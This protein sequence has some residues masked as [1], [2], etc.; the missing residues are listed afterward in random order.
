MA[1]QCCS[2]KYPIAFCETS[3]CESSKKL[4]KPPGV[5]CANLPMGR[6]RST[7]EL[8]RPIARP[9]SQPNAPPAIQSSPIPTKPSPRS[10]FTLNHCRCDMPCLSSVGEFITTIAKRNNSEITQTEICN[11]PHP[12]LDYIVYHSRC[13]VACAIASFRW[14]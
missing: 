1:L 14:N 11:M 10:T 12:S 7:P 13:V 8:S 9:S 4:Y 2:A 6:Q 5:F 3:L